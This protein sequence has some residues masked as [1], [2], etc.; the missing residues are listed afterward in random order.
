VLT[1]SVDYFY[2]DPRLEPHVEYSIIDRAKYNVG[3]ER[4]P[5]EKL[6]TEEERRV[7]K[8][9]AGYRILIL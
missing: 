5:G 6:A 2:I 7:W 3:S 1:C 4:N 9:M 8:A